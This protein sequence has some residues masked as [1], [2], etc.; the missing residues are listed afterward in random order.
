VKALVDR[1]G[2]DHVDPENVTRVASAR[3]LYHFDALGR[4]AY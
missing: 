1:A 4:Q 3:T 2:F